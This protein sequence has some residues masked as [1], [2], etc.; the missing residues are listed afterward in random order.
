[1]S[2]KTPLKMTL[3]FKIG[4]QNEGLAVD[5]GCQACFGSER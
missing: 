1:M 4:D 5:D 3:V 2:E